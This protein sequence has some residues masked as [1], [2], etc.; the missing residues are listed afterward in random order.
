MSD[1]NASFNAVIL[2]AGI[3]SRLKPLTNTVPKALIRVNNRSIIRYELEAL[4]SL[5]VNLKVYVVVGYLGKLIADEIKQLDLG[6]D[7]EIVENVDYDTTNNMY[8]LSLAMDKIGNDISPTVILNGDVI[9]DSRIIEGIF[10]DERNDL[11]AVDVGAYLEE[12]MKVI[13]ENGN[14]VKI[15]KGIEERNA[16]GTS[17]DLYKLSVPTYITLKNKIESIIKSGRLRD[18][19]E[20]AIDE[21][22]KTGEYPAQAFDIEK[23]PWWEI[24]NL[25]DLRIAEII[26]KKDSSLGNLLEKDLFV[27][28]FDGTLVLGEYPTEGALEFINFL[29][30]NKKEVVIITNNSSR[31]I[32]ETR[33]TASRI[34]NTEFKMDEVFSSTHATIKYLKDN[35]LT[36]V[37]PVG[38]KKF[39]KDLN[40]SGISNTEN[41]PAA[42][43]VGFDTELTYEKLR[44]ATLLLR[45]KIP[46]IATHSDLVCPTDEGLI[47]DAGAIL[48][49]LQASSER[50]PD[51]ILGKPNTVFI[52]LIAESK[53]IQPDK[54]AVFGDR[55]YTDMRMGLESGCLS[56]LVLT[57]ETRVTN[58]SNTPYLPHFVFCS[59][60]ELHEYW[61]K[62]S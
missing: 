61:Q 15:S 3:G 40:E 5:S 44:K 58:L 14:L 60:G 21:L 38:T 56:I 46:Y 33:E 32:E 62:Q 31:G 22:L 23:N 51:I 1:N 4:A 17:I 30:K 19:T 20:V 53:G 37:Y 16:L 8:S 59:L 6:I 36:D 52:D 54:I 48:A 42:V 47:P 11:I 57:G 13:Q 7:V 12:S 2:A 26:F 9:Y 10:R 27:F 18:W 29:R 39:I 34:L 24:D 55:L 35:N 28:D 25:D 45:G 49:L 41:D 43:V 50:E